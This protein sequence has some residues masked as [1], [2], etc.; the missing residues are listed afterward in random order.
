MNEE[1]NMTRLLLLKKK[2]RDNVLPNDEQRYLDRLQV[3][4]KKWI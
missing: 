4:A 3:E 1:E 2:Q